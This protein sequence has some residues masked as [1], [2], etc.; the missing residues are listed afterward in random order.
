MNQAI[1]IHRDRV[2][3]DYFQGKNWDKNNEFEL[4]RKLVLNSSRLLPHL[5]YL[6]DDEW[7]VEASRAEQG[8][9]DL[10]FTDGVGHYAVVEV[11]WIDS[12]ETDR[13]SRTRRE[14][15]RRKRKEVKEQALKY[16]AIF[17]DVW[18]DT[19]LVQAFTFTNAAEQP[20]LI[21]TLKKIN[22]TELEE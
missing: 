13:Q 2:L 4:K 18:D 5:P 21:K 14:S 20:E 16:A 19:E 17:L 22:L 6:V 3:R 11:K 7:E 9:G 10:V 15:N 8:R 1:V 12:E